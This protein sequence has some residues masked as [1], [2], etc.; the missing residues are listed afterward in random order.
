MSDDSH[1]LETN[2]PEQQLEYS[3]INVKY[4][5]LYQRMFLFEHTL[6]YDKLD[7]LYST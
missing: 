5:A 4:S 6:H 3:I 2:I 7:S 1:V